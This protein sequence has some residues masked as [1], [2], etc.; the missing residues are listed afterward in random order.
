MANRNWGRPC[1]QWKHLKGLPVSEQTAVQMPP[2]Q[3]GHWI[4]VPWCSLI[5]P[6]LIGEG[7]YG[8]IRKL[9]Q[10]QQAYTV[11]TALIICRGPASFSLHFIHCLQ[12]AVVAIKIKL[13]E[14]PH[15]LQLPWGGH[16]LWSHSFCG[17]CLICIIEQSHSV[18]QPRHRPAAVS[19]CCIFTEHLHIYIKNETYQS[20]TYLCYISGHLCIIIPVTSP[21]G[22][23]FHIFTE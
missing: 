18:C 15:T 5:P 12:A 22:N 21:A 9:V 20:I 6:K 8:K 4:V 14:Q 13:W 3:S 23:E 7:C 17:H 2:H 19:N 11:I 16:P 1:F 10:G